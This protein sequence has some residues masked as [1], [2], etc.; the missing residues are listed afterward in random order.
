MKTVRELIEGFIYEHLEYF[1][2][3]VDEGGLDTVFEGVRVLDEKEKFVH[4]TLIDMTTVLYQH[5]LEEND[6]R[7]QITEKRIIKF[8]SFVKNEDCKTWGKFAILRALYRLSEIGR[9]DIVDKETLDILKVKTDYT[10]FFDKKR[11]VTID[12]PTN[13]VQVAMAIAGL[14]E[15][16]GFDNDGYFEIIKNR[17]IELMKTGSQNGWMDEDAPY[18]RFDRYSLIVSSELSDNF[19]R[20][21]KDLPEFILVNLKDAAEIALFMANNKGDGINYGRS[22]S[23]HGDSAAVEIISAALARDLIEDKDKDIAVGYSIKIIE[24]VLDFWYDKNRHSFNIW[25]D[26]R[27]TNEYRQ[28]SRVLE[29]NLDMANHLLCVLNNFKIAGLSDYAPKQK[30]NNEPYWQALEIAFKDDT[31]KAK[32]YIL[33]KGDIMCMLPL[34]G[35]GDLYKCAAYMPYP[36]ICNIIEAAPEAPEPFLIPEYVLKD[37]TRVRPIQFYDAID[38]KSSESGFTVTASGALTQMDEDKYPKE[39]DGRFSAE[40]TFKEN[41]IE[42]KF[43]ISVPY[44]K[45][46]MECGTHNGYASIEA[47]GFDTEESI[48]TNAL[49]DYMTPHGYITSATR[50]EASLN[51]RV[52]YTVNLKI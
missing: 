29:V 2:S 35:L 5:Y 3:L 19:E 27:S 34:V 50:Y 9:L 39:Y 37:G 14:R 20:I 25:W 13:Y 46:I 31:K 41:T 45:C 22:L 15:A 36:N 30:I 47:N 7:A 42:A 33:K 26:G 49:Y 21:G 52:G 4:G 12:K 28:V 8:I 6:P 38:I 44:E 43:D 18:C 11:L 10:D 1:V 32:T 23:C 51:G 48:N 24:K 40:Y 17:L 16:I